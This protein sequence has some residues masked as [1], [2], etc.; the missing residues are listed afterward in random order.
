MSD[1]QETLNIFPTTNERYPLRRVP[2]R[3]QRVAKAAPRTKKAPQRRLNTSAKHTNIPTKTHPHTHQR[4]SKN[5]L[6]FTFIFFRT[7]QYNDIN[8]PQIPSIN[9]SPDLQPQIQPLNRSLDSFDS[10]LSKRTSSDNDTPYPQTSIVPHTETQYTNPSQTITTTQTQ[11]K[12]EYHVSYPLT[13]QSDIEEV[14]DT[15]TT[16]QQ[17]SLLTSSLTALPRITNSIITRIAHNIT[18]PQSHL[19]LSFAL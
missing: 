16:P 9:V 11:I 13:P 10:P 4:E 15:P 2:Q 14:I 19:T 17:P 18:P 8:T 12:S 3:T 7:K 1:N 5:T 6:T